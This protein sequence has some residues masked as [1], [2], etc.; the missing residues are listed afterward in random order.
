MP[1]GP[2][3]VEAISGACTMVRREAA[4][5]VGPWDE[6]FFVHCEDLDWCMRFRAA[7]W[8]I[9]FVPDAP[10]VHHRGMCSRSR[11]LFV[12]WHKHKGMVRFYRKHFRHQY[13]LGL[14]GLVIAGVWLRFTVVAARFAMAVLP[15]QVARLAAAL[16]RPRLPLPDVAA[17]SRRRP[18]PPASA[19]S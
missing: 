13:P 8:R 2:I 5:A 15:R 9:R 1:G 16:M 3:D 4:A 12:E 7:G 10:A 19:P 6:G 11:P 18:A 14:M 17:I